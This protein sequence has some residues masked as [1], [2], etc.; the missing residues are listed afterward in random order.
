MRN[1]EKGFTL[2]EVMV[3]AAI[4]TII[5]F[6]AFGV[7]QASNRQLQIIHAKMTL[8][9]RLREALFKMAQEIRQAPQKVSGNR[10][11]LTEDGIL[12]V[13]PVN[14][15]ERSS[16]IIFSVPDAASLVVDGAYEPI[17]TTAIEY[18]RG[19]PTIAGETGNQ[20]FRISTDAEGEEKQAILASDV[21][22]LEFSRKTDAPT[23]ITI[24][25]TAEKE[26]S[27]GDAITVQATAQAEARN[28]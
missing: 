8:Q 19:V 9:E 7:L 23:L 12:N 6:G 4:S 3:A 13:T 5:V 10:I 21:T 25:L 1:M 11:L 22:G 15:I 14:G 2:V 27:S 17:W 20:L 16:K 24:T 26:L 18:R 28:P